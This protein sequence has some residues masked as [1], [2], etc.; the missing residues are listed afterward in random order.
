MF[1]AHAERL[2]VEL[3]QK[4]DIQR[5]RRPIP[6]TL[7]DDPDLGLSRDLEREEREKERVAREARHKESVRAKI[8]VRYRVH[9]APACSAVPPAAT[10][11]Q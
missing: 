3:K 6:E 2:R 5:G 1:D 9:P 4:R 7:K 11:G 8:E 10:R